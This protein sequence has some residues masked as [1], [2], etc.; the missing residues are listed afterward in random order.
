[1]RHPLRYGGHTKLQ[2]CAAEG[3]KERTVT[4]SEKELYRKVKRTDWGSTWEE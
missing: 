4:R 2:L 3:L 1:V